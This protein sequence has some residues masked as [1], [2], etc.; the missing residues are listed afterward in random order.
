MSFQIFNLLKYWIV[1]PSD[2]FLGLMNFHRE[3]ASNINTMLRQMV[4]TPEYRHSVAGINHILCF[5]NNGRWLPT[6]PSRM[7][8]FFLFYQ[9]LPGSSMDSIV[10]F[11]PN[12]IQKTKRLISFIFRMA[13]AHRLTECHLLS[14]FLSSHARSTKKIQCDIPKTFSVVYMN[15]SAN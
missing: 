3:E 5:L 7:I 2:H 9:K 10:L 6:I 14:Y 11:V 8:G 4:F 12:Q 15:I 13:S 1:S